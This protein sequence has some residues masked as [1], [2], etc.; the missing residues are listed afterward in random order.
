MGGRG[1]ELTPNTNYEKM[2][3]TTLE[4][5]NTKQGKETKNQVNVGEAS[6]SGRARR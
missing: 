3:I 1:G 2:Y 5:Q 4:M 6:S